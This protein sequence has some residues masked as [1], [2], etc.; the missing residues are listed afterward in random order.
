MSASLPTTTASACRLDAGFE[1][2]FDVGERS[3][4]KDER[5]NAHGTCRGF[6]R[7]PFRRTRRIGEV[8]QSRDAGKL[9]KHVVQNFDAL[10]LSPGSRCAKPGQIGRGS[11][12][13]A[14]HRHRIAG[15]G[16]NHR[17]RCG[18]GLGSERRR[19]A[20]CHDHV[21]IEAYQFAREIRKA[22]VATSRRTVF[23][24]EVVTFD[25]AVLGK[26]V[27]QGAEIG[28]A[29][30]Q[31]RVQHPDTVVPRRGLRLRHQG[32]RRHARDPDNEFSPSH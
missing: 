10:L 12:Q 27:P 3:H 19:R 21:D 5:L 32:R 25:I 16:H 4:V 29:F 20:S 18:C 28:I 26:S 17:D 13:A 7:V 15:C 9:R 24:G 1:R 31:R 23:E 2:A 11:L 22:F 6:G 14:G 8:R 30:P